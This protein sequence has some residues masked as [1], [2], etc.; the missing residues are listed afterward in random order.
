MA[1]MSEVRVLR[2][3]QIYDGTGAPP[4]PGHVVVRGDRIAD[5][6]PD[7][8]IPAG[9]RDLEVGGLSVCP[10]FIDIHSHS[11][12][13][14][15]HPE[16][17]DLLRP[18]VAQGITTQVVG[19]CGL[20]VAPASPKHLEQLRAFMSLVVPGDVEWS[21]ESFDG[22]LRAV[23]HAGPPLN[24]VPLAAHGALRCTVMGAEPGPARG[25]AL[26]AIVRELDEALSAGA[27]GL[28]AGLIYPPGLWADTDELRT[29]CRRVAAADGLFTCHVRGSS[30]TALDAVAELLELA[31]S[32]GVRVQHSHHEAFGSSHWH[33]A[34][35]TLAMEEAARQEG[36]DVAS[37]VI[38]YHA[39]NTTL[40]AVYPPWA[41]AGGVAELCRRLSD[42]ET[43][44]RIDR[45]TRDR[46][47][48]W[49]PWEDGWAHNLVRATGWDNIVLLQSA[50]PRHRHWTGRN[51]AEIA[52][53]EGTDALHCAAEVTRSAGGDVMARYHGVTGAPDD[54][55][56]LRELLAHPRHAVGV[57][58]ILKEAGVP[59]PGGYGAFPRLLGTYARD[60]RWFSLEQAI[61]KITSL[62]AERLGLTDRG[63]LAPGKVADLVVFDADGIDEQGTWDTPERAPTGIHTVM[64]NGRI[65]LHGGTSAARRP[66]RL[67][68][69]TGEPP[70]CG[71]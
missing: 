44:D 15:L 5:L 33:L 39:V 31:R 70:G 69:R 38:P 64:V 65:A 42:P 51:L 19:N 10:G 28:S 41:L 30:E 37:D 50:S 55:E 66:G 32:T 68:R 67:L 46:A 53:A 52:R 13:A 14:V 7:A 11:D 4:R 26:E 1:S 21:W 58:V 16:A 17:P 36:I 29:L 35:T 9:A 63:R 20:G 45:E 49:P 25:A 34:R 40:L 54:D 60:R 43:L 2:D 27:F 62:P 3:V 8:R 12:L 59:H 57:D 23:E 56:V 71:P 48:R 24:V 18:F 22:W 61:R 6:G 47:P